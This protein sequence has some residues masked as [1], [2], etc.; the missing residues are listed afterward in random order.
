MTG[1]D[2]TQFFVKPADSIGTVIATIDRSGR[3]SLALVV[4]KRGRLLNTVSDGDVRRGILAGLSLDE[5]VSKL[6]EIKAR[7]PYPEAVTAR[8]GSDPA[9]L[10]QIM[11]QRSVRQLP[12]VNRHN[13]VVDIVILSDFQRLASQP[14]RAVVMAGGQG[15]RLRPLTENTPK[16]MLPVG[17]RPL[18]EHIVAQL[19]DV[20]VRRIHV[21]THYQADKIMQHFGGGEAFGVEIKYVREETPLGT[22]GALGLLDQPQ[23]PVLVINGDIL[24]QV[25]FRAMHTFHQDHNAEMTVAVRRYDV[26]VP[27]GVVECDGANIRSLR[28]KPQLSFFVNAGIYLLEPSVFGLISAGQHLNITDLVSRLMEA[29][30]TVVSYP[31]CEYWLDIGQQDDYRRAQEDA[32]VGRLTHPVDEEYTY[33]AT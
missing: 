1:R 31:V 17:G 30:R 3:V 11:Q 26:Q 33:L 22:G 24:T 29:Q 14:F 27:Y 19:R 25:D 9:T 10:L 32:L 28:E 16:P 4:D 6:L 15:A 18:L 7:T 21:T 20:G 13:R 2:V 8:A 5:S 23:E 12:L